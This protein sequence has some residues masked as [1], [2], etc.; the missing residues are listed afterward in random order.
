MELCFT[1][2]KSDEKWKLNRKHKNKFKENI[3]YP[4]LIKNEDIMTVVEVFAEVIHDLK[5]QLCNGHPV[6]MNTRSATHLSLSSSSVSRSAHVGAC[7]CSWGGRA[8]QG[9]LLATGLT[10]TLHDK[11]F[12]LIPTNLTTRTCFIAFS[13]I[14]G[15][16]SYV[17]LH[18]NT[19]PK[20]LT[21]T[22]LKQLA[23]SKML[24]AF[25]KQFL[26]CRKCCGL[27]R[28]SYIRMHLYTQAICLPTS[29]GRVM[30]WW[31]DLNLSCTFAI[32]ETIT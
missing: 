31:N 10:D 22:F 11:R 5:F 26:S 18:R 14:F 12:P 20:Y 15:I 9:P 4:N 16:N 1:A 32:R 19:R 7:S 2:H 28:K 21:L 17:G 3:K 24:T 27:S 29:F 13:V 23:W 25:M 6:W 8:L 30:T